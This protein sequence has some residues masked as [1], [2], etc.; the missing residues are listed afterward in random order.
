[1]TMTQ[2][3]WA[4]MEVLWAE[5]PCTLGQVVQALSGTKGWSRNTVYTYLNRMAAKGLVRVNPDRKAPY[6]AGVSREECRREERKDLLSRVYG[7][8]TGELVAAFLQEST[9]TPQ[10]R[11]RLRKLLDEMEV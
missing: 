11:D 10:E 3:E 1:M 8:K 9:I 4:I 7:G 2:A 6:E 5:G